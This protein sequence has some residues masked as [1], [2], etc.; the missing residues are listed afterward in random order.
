MGNVRVTHSGAHDLRKQTENT[1]KRFFIVNGSLLFPYSTVSRDNWGGYTI[2]KMTTMEIDNRVENLRPNA[3][4]E[5]ENLQKSHDPMIEEDTVEIFTKKEQLQWVQISLQGDLDG[6]KVVEATQAIKVHCFKILKINLVKIVFEK[7]KKSLSVCFETKEDADLFFSA[8]HQ[9]ILE[10]E[11]QAKKTTSNPELDA[12]K[13]RLSINGA[14]FIDKKAVSLALSRFGEVEDFYEVAST[15]TLGNKRSFTVAFKALESKQVMEKLK[16]VT[17]GNVVYKVEPSIQGPTNGAVAQRPKKIQLKLNGID[18]K[19]SDLSLKPLMKSMNATYWHFVRAKNGNKM[20]MVMAE[21]E[22]EAAKT[23]A[24]SQIFYFQGKKIN[25][26]EPEVCCCFGCGSLEHKWTLCSENKKSVIP[27]VQRK[28]VGLS[29]RIV[30]NKDWAEYAQQK[31]IEASR[32]RTP[33]PQENDLTK[34]LLENIRDLEARISK[35]E[36][37]K[38]NLEAKIDA[39]LADREESKRER[40]EMKDSQREMKATLEVLAGA[41][42]SSQG[43]MKELTDSHHSFVKSLGQLLETRETEAGGS[44]K[45][46]KTKN[47]A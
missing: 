44:K 16:F 6:A 18:T 5:D 15:S 13:I 8:N 1:C 42:I 35:M 19:T 3:K 36:V 37:D 17:V 45:I 47:G 26:T 4:P 34:K 27:S 46:L 12:R 43:Q 28:N 23:L 9:A 31:S 11:S 32:T 40:K 20:P 29:A 30:N 7:A 39:M 41:M 24:M 21:F 22:D 25:V 33:Q 10:V 38:T 2:F 14:G